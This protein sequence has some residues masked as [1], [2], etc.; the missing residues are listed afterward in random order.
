MFRPPGYIEN[1]T[2]IIIW[3]ELKAPTNQLIIL[4]TKT[5]PFLKVYMPTYEI[6][7]YSGCPPI[8]ILFRMPTWFSTRLA[9]D[10]LINVYKLTSF[11]TR[12]ASDQLITV[13]ESDHGR[14]F[15]KKYSKKYIFWA[16]WA[17][18]CDMCAPWRACLVFLKFN[19]YN[20]DYSGI[21]LRR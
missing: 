5:P 15:I 12:F 21:N 14:F 17:S 2:F 9:S 19:W 7:K 6:R 16:A 20:C 3:P 4:S 13:A 1:G 10:Q 8:K 11:S 18:A